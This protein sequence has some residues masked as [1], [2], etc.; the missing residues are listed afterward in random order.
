MTPYNAALHGWQEK[1]A[2]KAKKLIH[3]KVHLGA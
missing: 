3:R 2:G 1:N